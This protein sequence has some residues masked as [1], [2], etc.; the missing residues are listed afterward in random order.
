M[1]RR[2]IALVAALLLP[3]ALAAQTTPIDPQ[4]PPMPAVETSPPPTIYAT[5]PAPAA[6]AVIDVDRIVVG[7]LPQYDTDGIEGLSATEFGTWM[8]QLFANAGRPAPTGE[9]LAAAFEQTDVSK[10]GLIQSGELALF[11]RGG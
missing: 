7:G 1:F 3:S 6:A 10:D 5:Q 8:A 2:T 11:L 9:Y 4:S